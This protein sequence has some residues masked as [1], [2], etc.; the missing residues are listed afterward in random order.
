MPRRPVPVS[1]TSPASSVPGGWRQWALGALCAVHALFLIFALIPPRLRSEGATGRL[2]AAYQKWTGS[3][4]RWD[5][6]ETIPQLHKLEAGLIE[7]REDGAIRRP[8]VILPE[9]SPYPAPERPRHYSL[10]HRM[11]WQ[12]DGPAYAD[13]FLQRVTGQFRNQPR[14]PKAVALQI[15][16]WHTRSLI[17]V[18]SLGEIAVNKIATYGPVPVGETPA[19]DTP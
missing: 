4:Q 1:H 2:L 10:F 3:E 9:L 16:A 5:M 19:P 13:A 8:G 12:P 17:G 15:D 18:K 11:I 14:P 6:F 7:V